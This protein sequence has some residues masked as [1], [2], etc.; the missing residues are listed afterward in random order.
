VE[1][2]VDDAGISHIYAKTDED[3]FYAAGYRMA[4]ERLYQMETLRRFAYGRLAEVLGEEALTRDLE[5]RT[6]DFP[7]WGRLD[8]EV[9]QTED[10]ERAALLEAWVRGINRRIDE[11]VR[12]DAPLPFGYTPGAWDFVPERWEDV[13]PYVVLKGA[14]FALDLTLEFE[15]AVSL[16]YSLY[17]DAMNSVEVLKPAHPVYSVPADER[18]Q[19]DQAEARPKAGQ[20]AELRRRGGEAAEARR[21]A[22]EAAEAGRRAGQ[23]AGRQLSGR[24]IEADRPAPSKARLRLMFRALERL[25]A[26]FPHASGSNNWAIDGRNTTTGMPLLAGD[27]HLSFDFFGAPYPLHLNSADAGGT[28]DVAGFAYPGTPGIAIGHNAHVLWSPT[29]AFGDVMDIWTV[30][31]A[32]GRANMGGE[33]V[34]I[35]TRTEEIIV[36]GE[37]MPAG[38]GEVQEMTYEEVPGYGVIVPR[39]VLGIPT[40]GK[41]L[42]NWTGFAGRPARWFMEL[43]RV[44]SLDELE[45]AVDRMKEMNYNF[46]GADKTGI[47]L[48]VG[49]DV[50]V[51]ADVSGDRGPWRA[52]DASD[53]LSLWPGGMLPAS[54][55]PHSRGLERGWLAT[56]NNDP[57]G[58]TGDGRIDDDPWFYGA[59]FDPGYRASRIEAELSRLA[60]RGQVTLEDMQHLQMDTRSTLADDLLPLLADAHSRIDTDPALEQFRGR[61]D[62]DQVVQLLSV[63]WDRRMARDSAGALAFNAWMH[64]V[65]AAVL[66]DDIPAAYDFAMD[67]QTI[68]VMKVAALALLGAYP[69]GDEVLQ[70]G[71]ETI[72]LEAAV[73]VAEWLEK[74]YGAVDPAAFAYQDVKVTSFDDAYGYMMELFAKPS[75][76]G[77]DTICVSQNISFSERAKQWVSTYVSVERMVG[78]FAP[79]GTPEAYVNYPVGPDSDPDSVDTQNA[80]ADYLDGRYRKLLFRR[81]EIEP[82]V[83]E[84]LTLIPE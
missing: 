8:Y 54:Q 37:G 59:F 34:P 20:A 46:V 42:C 55:L 44:S 30:E 14:G 83:R 4:T 22:G 67:L 23:A 76:G 84:R 7:R 49:V 47:T 17:P 80:N 39:E 78:T 60:A 26:A 65:T 10:P 75:D 6:F 15:Y 33:Q 11:I 5:A 58:F 70:E 32:D 72:L 27:P 57:F 73:S 40:A 3:L 69:S 68:Y 12:G 43:N 38:K 74:R 51:R 9:M 45:Q 35:T 71:R 48:R 61:T 21:R 25:L 81:D 28:Y 2:L 1:I 66:E 52:M 77:E 62:L 29:S 31:E 24:R 19:A 41:L 16:L 64:Y 50:P 63:D 53:P 79:D 56:A 36:R 18:P 13:D 82:V